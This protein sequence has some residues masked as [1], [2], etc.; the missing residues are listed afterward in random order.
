MTLLRIQRYYSH[1]YVEGELRT[2]FKQPKPDAVNS[3][4]SNECL[5]VDD[6]EPVEDTVEDDAEPVED[7]AEP[8]AINSII[9]EVY[10]FDADDMKWLSE[11]S[12][13]LN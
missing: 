9:Q 7:D 13:G 8:I 6:A 1:I 2:I 11:M 10:N 3:V 5:I 12:K 4:V